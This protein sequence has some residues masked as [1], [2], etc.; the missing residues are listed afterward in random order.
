M[1]RTGSIGRWLLAGG[2][3]GLLLAGLA[4][5][6]RLGSW[7]AGAPADAAPRPAQAGAAQPASPAATGDRALAAGSTDDAVPLAP[8]RSLRDTE[9]D[10]GLGQDAGG[11]FDPTPEA[12]ALF[13]YFLSATGEEPDDVIRQRIEGE[14]SR[15][16]PPEPAREA[17]AL[18]GM[19]RRY[20]E[21]IRKLTTEGEPPADL[22]RRFQ[23]VREERRQA[24]GAVL[25]EK[26]F[27]EEE[28]VTA[29]DL[30]RRRV[31]NDAS[32]S[33]EEKERR[34]A[35]LESDL[36][37]VVRE[38]RQQGTA[39]V[40]SARQVESLRA[41]GASAAEIFA[42]REREFGPEAAERLARLDQEDAAWQA[43]LDAYRGERERLLG[44]AS[45]PKEDR[46]ARIEALRVERF[47]A[48][49]QIRVRAL[50]AL[51]GR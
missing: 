10:G 26:L 14:I 34:L 5:E 50:D 28:R 23:R 27:G 24:F 30:E 49:E 29:V 20:R 39:I 17:L 13:D 6:R 38:K 4:L 48:Q 36:P 21:S 41:A 3:A 8:P 42:A 12:L 37:A 35:A 2:L 44:D 40:R 9:V 22:E 19:Y 11:H 46:D 33:G 25:A 15:R 7:Q 32:L 45:L 47:D 1:A 16:L 18:F 43:R 31:A 51:G